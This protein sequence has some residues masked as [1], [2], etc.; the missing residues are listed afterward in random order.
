MA[1][2][3]RPRGLID[4]CTLDDV[5]AEKAGEPPRP[6][7][8]TLLRP[9]TLIYMGVWSAIGLA[10]LFSL[11]QRTRLDLAVQHDRSPLYVQLSDGHVRN[12]YTLKLR[13]METRPREVEVVV[14]GLDGA[15]VWTET[16]SREKAGQRLQISLA[17]D[18]VTRLKLFIAAPAKGPAR[19]D[20]T[21]ETKGLDGDPRGDSETIQFDRPETGQ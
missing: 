3:G 14:S 15:Q 19:Q 6:V 10:M 16:G 13:N 12:N 4:Y 18:S 8:K 20:F 11:G 2:V 7:L 5:A 21:I 9:R 1:Q 17:P